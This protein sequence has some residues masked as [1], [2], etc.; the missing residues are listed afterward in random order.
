MRERVCV[1]KRA[2]QQIVLTTSDTDLCVLCQMGGY[3]F[4]TTVCVFIY[5]I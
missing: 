5:F 2:S 4:I 1:R 3:I